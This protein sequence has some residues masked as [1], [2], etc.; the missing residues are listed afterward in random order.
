MDLR[1]STT[2]YNDIKPTFSKK[3]NANNKYRSD[4]VKSPQND[5]FELSV[6]Y[7]NDTHGQTNNM[8]RILSGLKGDIVLSG[9]DNDIGD[10]KNKTIHD[11]TI[12]FL[13]M[14]CFL[15]KVHIIAYQNN[16]SIFPFLIEI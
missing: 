5:S 15:N 14:F 16:K 13:N 7:V 2:K 12:Q 3:E 4:F 1:I 9:G 8:M 6:G 10:E 11:A